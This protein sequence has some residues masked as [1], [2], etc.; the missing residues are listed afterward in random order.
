MWSFQGNS[1]TR[2]INALTGHVG[3][4]SHLSGYPTN[5]ESADQPSWGRSWQGLL[6]HVH[7]GHFRFALSLVSVL[8]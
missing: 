8:M 4:R 3:T 5:Q 2:L 7:I 6:C 1:G